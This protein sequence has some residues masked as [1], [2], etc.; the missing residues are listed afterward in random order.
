MR[1]SRVVL[2]QLDAAIFV[3]VTIYEPANDNSSFARAH[4]SVASK[5]F[6]ERNST[7]F[8][9][10]DSWPIWYMNMSYDNETKPS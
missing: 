5:S 2:S 1:P 10:H 8:P 9:L 4:T 6:L 7:S 3:H